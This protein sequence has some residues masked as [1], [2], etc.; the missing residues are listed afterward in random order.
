M[1][2]KTPQP[3]QK[4]EK[5]PTKPL[6]VDT[7]MDIYQW[8]TKPVSERY[9]EELGKKGVAWMLQQERPHSVTKFFRDQG[10]CSKDIKRWRGRSAVFNRAYELMMEIRADNLQLGALEKRYDATHVRWTLP[11]MGQEWKDLLEYHYRLK[12]QGEEKPTE[13]HVVLDPVEVEEDNS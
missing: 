10:I 6:V 13:L 5:E 3:T 12:H 1:K 11:K 2:S 8:K 9:L 7:Y 4:K